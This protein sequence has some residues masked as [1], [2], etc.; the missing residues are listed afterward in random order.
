MDQGCEL[1]PP[2]SLL[3]R[4]GWGEL[5]VQ[6]FSQRVNMFLQGKSRSKAQSVVVF[7]GEV[8]S[9]KASGKLPAEVSEKE[10]GFLSG[11]QLMIIMME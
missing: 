9:R 7:K 5:R 1:S 6:G 3:S 4:V 2:A 8:E 10:K 11:W